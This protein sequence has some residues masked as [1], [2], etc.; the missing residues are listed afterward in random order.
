M[1]PATCSLLKSQYSDYVIKSLQAL[2][3]IITVAYDDLKAAGGDV[4]V[5]ALRSASVDS[6]YLELA[7][8][9][10]EVEALTGSEDVVVQELASK[11]TATLKEL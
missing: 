4:T 7:R 11:L 3:A 5:E 8:L 1:L 2:E 6:I 9:E 10:V